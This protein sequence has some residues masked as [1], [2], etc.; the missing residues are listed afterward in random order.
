MVEHGLAV[1]KS[2]NPG[3]EVYD[4]QVEISG[5][6]LKEGDSLVIDGQAR[7]SKAARR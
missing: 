1:R 2:R 5:G 3:T 7:L 4:A 6:V